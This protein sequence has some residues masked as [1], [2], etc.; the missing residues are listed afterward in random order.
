[1]KTIRALVLD[2]DGTL[3]DDFKTI[4]IRLKKYL[5]Y[6]QKE[7][8]KIILASGRRISDIADYSNE[9]KLSQYGGY[10]VS[11]DGQYI[12]D[13]DCNLVERLPFMETKQV[14]QLINETGNKEICCTVHCEDKDI[15]IASIIEQF[16]NIL[17]RNKK[18]QRIFVRKKDFLKNCS[19]ENIEKVIYSFEKRDS[20]KQLYEKY[21]EKYS[22]VC[23]VYITDRKRI[24]F[25]SRDTD[26]YF[27][28]KRVLEK[29]SINEK[30]ILVFGD[31]YNDILM[32]KYFENSI[33][34]ENSD[35]EVKK[36]AKHM[37]LSNNN[38]GVLHYLELRRKECE[39]SI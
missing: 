3:L 12:Y 26:K 22:D 34:M 23:N 33:C 4:E 13:A 35:E 25:C 2:L 38:N 36:Y 20:L 37:T 31:S 16:K 19:N 21:Q 17:K 18:E 14:I 1:M 29:L 39:N 27:A 10:I 24:E 28:I 7:G 11:C 5:L 9:L 15:Y 32:M 8:I 30:Q 6:L